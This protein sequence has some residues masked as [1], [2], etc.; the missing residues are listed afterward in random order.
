V[1]GS[2]NYQQWQQWVISATSLQGSFHTYGL[3]WSPRRLTWTID[4]V[5]YATATPASLSS[6]AQWVFDGH[7]F[8]LQLDLAVGGWPGAPTS[9]TE[10][11]AS[12]LVDWVRVYD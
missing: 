12:M 4:G 7:P 11:P 6:N 8:S 3:I 1:S 10:F 2:T 9:T 5:P